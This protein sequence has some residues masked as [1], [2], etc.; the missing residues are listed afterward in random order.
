MI[1]FDAAKKLLDEF[2]FQTVLDVSPGL[3]DI[4]RI[5]KES[6]KNI[7]CVERK[8]KAAL[9]HMPGIKLYKCAFEEFD[10]D[11]KYDCVWSSH[12]LQLKDNPTVYLK[13]LLELAKPDGVLC[14]TIPDL[15]HTI[16]PD[17]LSIWN[18]GLLL[19]HLV[20]AGQDCS[21]ASVIHCDGSFSII[22]KRNEI[23]PAK[24]FAEIVNY[25]PAE[26]PI[27]GGFNGYIRGLNWPRPRVVNDPIIRFGGLDKPDAYSSHAPIL[28][29]CSQLTEGRVI[30]VGAG[31]Y[32]TPLLHALCR[33][34]ELITIEREAGW[35]EK[36]RCLESPNHKLIINRNTANVP[37]IDEPCGLAF[38]DGFTQDRVPCIKRLKDVADVIVCHDTERS[39]YGY[40]PI[41]STFKERLDYFVPPW[42]VGTTIVSDRVSLDKFRG[43]LK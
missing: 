24:N 28:A 19:V 43:L 38:V 9:L 15:Q 31:A 40:E 5:F 30:E 25:L 20:R 21:K 35:A 1:G 22:V 33:G 34:R 17:Q 3:G 29:A 11:E 4:A 26:I 37:E 23:Q 27:D 39:V 16:V 7:S 42:D 41:F 6:G 18:S 10:K 8:P 12:V 13:S 14:I 36:F 32:S 2:K